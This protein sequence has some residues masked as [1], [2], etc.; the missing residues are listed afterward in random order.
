MVGGGWEMVVVEER[1]VGCCGG[2]G[3]DEDGR[4]REAES[5]N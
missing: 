1:K 5:G 2:M 4:K 3:F